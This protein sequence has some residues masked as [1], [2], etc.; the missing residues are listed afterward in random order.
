[1]GA[2]KVELTQLIWKDSSLGL[3]LIHEERHRGLE[4]NEGAEGSCG[5]V[6]QQLCCHGY[7]NVQAQLQ[8]AGKRLHDHLVGSR[9]TGAC[10][11]EPG[12]SCTSYY[13]QSA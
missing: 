1:M 3:E 9:V 2:W 6:D 10:I 4:Q 8:H 13:M 5:W 12:S 11:T 7:G